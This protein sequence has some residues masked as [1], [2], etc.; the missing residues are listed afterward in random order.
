MCKHRSLSTHPRPGACATRYCQ[1]PVIQGQLPRENTRHASGWYNVTL[2]SAA[3]GS[4]CIPYPS[5]ALACVTQSSLIRCSF[6]PILSGRGT[7]ALRGPAC[8]GGAKSKAEPQELCE[9]RGER[10]ISPSS[11][12][13]SGLNLYNQLDVPCIVEYL[14]RERI[15]LKLRQWIWKQL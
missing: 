11:P 15:I 6:N 14:N 1:G 8:R 12:R 3:A 5:L 9:Q 7:D 13:S 4:P 2:A 10:E